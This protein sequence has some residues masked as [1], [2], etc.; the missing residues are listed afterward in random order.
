ML[1]LANSSNGVEYLWN[2]CNAFTDLTKIEID[3]QSII[4]QSQ[5]YHASYL[6]FWL[7]SLLA[8]DKL[9]N[10]THAFLKICLSELADN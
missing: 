1:S 4:L 2:L 10:G 8:V 9:D 5:I 7:E 3:V 6:R